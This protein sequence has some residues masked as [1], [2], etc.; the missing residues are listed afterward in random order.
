MFVT[1]MMAIMFVVVPSQTNELLSLLSNRSE[2]ER[3]IFYGSKDTRHI[4]VCGEISD[5]SEV[6]FEEMFHEDH[7]R[8]AY[9][10]KAVIL[11]A[12]K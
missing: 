3:A 9:E 7:G 2:Y 11:G 10:L 4:L 8:D 5:N 1:I 12:N 6:F